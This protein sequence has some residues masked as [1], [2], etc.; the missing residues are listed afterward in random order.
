MVR[1]V[2]MGTPD[3]AL[4]SLQALLDTQTVVGVVT[5]PDRPAGRGRRLTSSPVKRLAEAA[6]VPVLQPPSL[7]KPEAAAPLVAWAPDLIVVAAFGQI[8]RPHV[9]DLPRYG[10][11]NVHASLL[12]RWRGAAPIQHAILGGDQQTGITLMQMDVGLDTGPMFVSR[13]LAIAPDET[14]ATLHDRL[15]ALGGDLLR[16][17]L[18]EILSGDLL[19]EIQDES[20]ATYAPRIN[21]ED[22]AV[23]WTHPAD[24]L[25]RLV[26]AMTPW[27]GAFTQWGDRQLKVL[28]AQ[29]VEAGVPGPPGL[30]HLVNGELTVACAAGALRLDA[31]QLEGRRPMDAAAFL[32]GQP[33]IVGSRLGLPLA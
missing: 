25:D 33:E 17:H 13:A 26:R 31:L 10:C 28:A 32:N 3:F 24:A 7:R 19:P 2:F 23:D 8:L 12:P 29:P 20:L 6:G 30:V 4:P 14:A 27:P 22:G 15:A 1:I 11:L 5:Q 21:K 9:L 16:D 18:D